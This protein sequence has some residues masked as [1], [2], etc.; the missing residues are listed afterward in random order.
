MRFDLRHP[1]SALAGESGP[2]A[3]EQVHWYPVPVHRPLQCR[4][5]VGGGFGPSDIGAH[6][7]AGVVVEDLQ[8]AHHGAVGEAMLKAVDLPA[9]VGGGALEAAA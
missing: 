3:G 9:P 7:E 6:V 5:R 4:P 8:D 2:V 1:A